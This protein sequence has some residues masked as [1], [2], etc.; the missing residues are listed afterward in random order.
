MS[1][2][3]H[4]I[5][6]WI[7]VCASGFALAAV[8]AQLEGPVAALRAVG[9]MGQGNEEAQKAWPA[10]AVAEAQAL[11][12][13]LGAMDGANDY[14]LNWLR[15]AV[16]TIVQRETTAGRK[17]PLADLETFLGDTRHHPRARR[18]AYELILQV[19][20]DRARQLVP[21]F[22]ND[23]ANELRRDAVQLLMEAAT[24][25]VA[26]DQPVAVA[27]YRQALAAARDAD[28]IDSIAKSLEGLGEK[29]DLRQTFGWVTK[30]KLVGPFDNTGN[31]GFARE[32]PPEQQLDWT[33]EYEGKTGRVKWVEYETKSDYGLVDF[34]QPLGS[35]KEV[36]G[37]AVAEFWSDTARTAEIRLGS[38]NGWKVWVNGTFLFGRDEYHTAA[39]IDQFRLPV[40]LQAGRNTLLV[41]CTQN[42][43]TED[44]T[45]EW[46]FQLRVTDA[47]GTPLRSSQ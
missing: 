13:I 45:Q 3:P 28:Q 15:A 46:E 21:G 42:A 16:E 6:G 34:N 20:P 24:N 9:P 11:T 23:P 30:W 44:W 37:Y 1:L 22:V 10:V 35:L 43:Q 33:A 32:Y 14:A 47:Q 19:D 4:L 27:E 36:A 29:V 38:K 8:P 25:R 39:E 41:K 31:A 26:L 2:V 17:L 7:M 12:G 40:S 18:L 5:A